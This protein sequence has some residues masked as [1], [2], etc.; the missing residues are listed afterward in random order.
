MTTPRA[1][2]DQGW[3]LHQ[4]GQ[5]RQ[6]EEIYRAL[7]RADPRDARVWFV[8]GSLCE[9]DSRPDEAVVHVC[10]A[11]ELSPREP[12]GHFALGNV[13]LK[14]GRFAEGELAFRRC[15]GLQPEHAEALGNLGYSLAELGRHEEARAAYEQ[16]LR[17]RPDCAEIHYNLGNLL[18]GRY[19]LD[20]AVACYR[21]ALELRPDYAQ[22]HV[23]LGVALAARGELEAA[24]D[25][26]RR[27]VALRPDL[28]EAHDSLGAVLSA[29]GRLDEALAC[30]ERALALKP[31]FADARWNRG[32]AR[33]LLGDFAG[34]WADYEWRWRCRRLKPPPALTQPRWDG[35]PLA[36]RT[37]LL[38][39]EQ[40]LGDT[41]QF[42]RYVPLVEARGGRV[43][44]QC[45]DALLPLLSRCFPTARFVGYGESAPACD[46][47][48]PLL[49]LPG[50]LGTTLATIP[51]RVPYLFA[52]P[53]L[54][55]HWRRELAP[56]RGFRVGIAWQGSPQHPWDRHRSVPL[57]VFE[58]LARVPGV[59]LVSLQRGPGYEQ[60]ASLAGRFPLV[61]PGDQVDRVAGALMDTAAI[62]GRLDLV[63][64]VDTSFAHLAGALGVPLW[65]ALPF[66]PDWR[67]MLRR[68][69]SP[70][71]PTA[72]LF[73][74]ERPGDWSG[75]FARLA[76]ALRETVCRSRR[77]EPLLVE[78]SPGEL[79][80][81][82]TGLEVEES[83]E[84]DPARSA[85]VRAARQALEVAARESLPEDAALSDL[86]AQLC[87]AH[88]HLRDVEAGLRGCEATGDFGP[89]FTD[90]ARAARRA[91]DRRASLRRD[92]DRLLHS[93]VSMA[94]PVVEGEPAG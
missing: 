29:G 24:A 42:I 92:I 63:I 17:L 34:G 25:S 54:A 72:R 58:P 43:V 67:W 65:L 69:D 93:R 7:L 11:L 38:H 75:V 19:D 56:V 5:F 49:S 81:R 88:E 62:M 79:L 2:F 37:A 22:A 6:A 85:H 84:R 28:P 73:R 78:V 82:L 64:S 77:A 8:L 47:W 86:R 32:L 16:A 4:A 60:I 53:D 1:S 52:D 70:W 44:V 91:N 23:N 74:Q 71:Y 66:S 90:L 36:G 9:A 55:A 26:L 13:L 30:Y 89:R 40:G 83:H 68:A 76:D 27:A 12:M 35:A 94:P 46:V 14:L 50:L 18:R 15:L 48:A 10:Q 80:D 57:T 59:R 3:Q 39:A 21:R 61:T 41:L 33:L 45:Q 31:D 51:A 20:G 87:A